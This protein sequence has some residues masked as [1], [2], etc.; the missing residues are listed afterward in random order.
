MFRRVSTVCLIVWFAW[1]CSR[2]DTLPNEK[3]ILTFQLPGFASVQT[4]IDHEKQLIVLLL[5]YNTLLKSLRPSFELSTGATSVPA[6]G[7]EQDFSKPVYYTLTATDGSKIVYQ[8]IVR[9]AEQPTPLVTDFD[10]DTLEAGQL[11]RVSG[12]YF[13]S[14]ALDVKANLIDA[15]NQRYPCPANYQDSTQ[16]RLQVPHEVPPSRYQVE[17]SVRQKTGLSRRSVMVSYPTPQLQAL[18]KFNILQGDTLRLTSLYVSSLYQYAVLIS[19]Q[20]LLA[21]KSSDGKISA[22]IPSTVA[23][24]SYFVSLQNLSL[25]KTS[26]VSEKSVRI[27]DATNPFVYGIINPKS[28]YQSAETV[29]FSTHNFSAFPTRFYQIQFDT[30]TRSYLQNGVYDAKTKVLTCTLPANMLKGKYQLSVALV[31]ANGT[32]FEIELDD[33]INIP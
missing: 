10:R 7:A 30:P 24:G 3:K 12:Q 17:V 32:S 19:R 23:A 28:S 31:N 26:Q 29:R 21:T 20:V 6:S 1:S 25:G 2:N 18:S 8:V 15:Q 9:T 16:L 33:T 11:L 14:F 27:Y 22:V 5:P 13:G 4:T